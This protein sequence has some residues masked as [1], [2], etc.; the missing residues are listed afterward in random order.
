LYH[1]VCRFL[2]LLESAQYD[3]YGASGSNPLKTVI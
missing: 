2:A 1:Q 3:H